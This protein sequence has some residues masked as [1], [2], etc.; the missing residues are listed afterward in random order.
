MSSPFVCGESV[1]DLQDVDAAVIFANPVQELC[2]HASS[3]MGVAVEE[4]AFIPSCDVP[5]LRMSAIFFAMMYLQPSSIF[6][7][8][9][10]AVRT[11]R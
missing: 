7:S 9:C 6:P 10:C 8:L 5:S 4:T 3:W 2:W 1:V 11:F